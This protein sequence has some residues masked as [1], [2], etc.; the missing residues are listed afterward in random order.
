MGLNTP[1]RMGYHGEGGLTMTKTTIDVEQEVNH[2]GS[3]GGTEYQKRTMRFIVRTPDTPKG[4]G[5]W[6]GSFEW[7]D[8]ESGGEDFYAEGGLWFNKKKE[9]VDYDGVFCL[10][11]DVLDICEQQG[12]D[13][14]DMKESLKY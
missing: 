4:D 1:L 12:F 14:D 2:I 10:P 5:S 9:M 8:L 7:Y 6:Y 11:E 3:W 13:I